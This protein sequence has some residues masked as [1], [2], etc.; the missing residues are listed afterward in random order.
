MVLGRQ[1][2]LKLDA[3]FC[4]QVPKNNIKYSLGFLH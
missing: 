2:L 3:L 1:N 4:L